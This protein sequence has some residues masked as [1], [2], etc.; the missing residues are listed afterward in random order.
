MPQQKKRKRQKPG[1]FLNILILIIAVLVVFEGKLLI[2]IFKEENIQTQVNSQVSE[3]LAETITEA[4][5]EP[6]TSAVPVETEPQTETSQPE[7]QPV[8]KA[9]VPEQS[10]PVDDS[11]F[12]DAVFI[13]DSRMQGFYNQS[14]ISQ[15]TFLTG[16]GMNAANIFDTPYV[17]M[18]EE[19]ITVFQALYNTDYKKMY[20]LIGTNDLGEPDFDDF[21]EQYR[22]CLAELQKQA[23]NAIMYVLSVPYVEESK[24]TTGDY[25]NNTNIEI[26]NE[27]ILEICEEYNYNYINLNEVLSDGNQSLIEGS[28]ADGIHMYDTYLKIWL[29]YLKTH[30]VEPD[31]TSGSTDSKEN[32]QGQTGSQESTESSTSAQPDGVNE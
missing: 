8:S 11:Y 13:G 21:K 30:Y 22:I 24:V 1:R 28:T 23:P 19:Q 14:G 5:T 26:V 17:T 7:T 32:T 16:V 3:L 2:N 12:S 15:G 10:V 25:V 6:S 18:Y 4:E 29:D 20:V 9:I 31:S 27:K